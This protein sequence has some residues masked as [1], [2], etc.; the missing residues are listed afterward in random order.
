MG[1]KRKHGC[2]LHHQ[3][4]ALPLSRELRWGAGYEFSTFLV[5]DIGDEDKLAKETRERK[6]F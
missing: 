4:E 2:L 5:W 3:A 6:A 1:E